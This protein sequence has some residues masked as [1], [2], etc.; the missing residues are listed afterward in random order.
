MIHMFM[1]GITQVH[2]LVCSC[3][4]QGLVTHLAFRPMLMWFGKQ[5]WNKIG[6]PLPLES[7]PGKRWD[8][9]SNSCSC[10]TALKRVASTIILF[11]LCLH[12]HR[13]R[14]KAQLLNLY[15]FQLMEMRTQLSEHLKMK[16]QT[17]LISFENVFKS[18]Y[19]QIN[20]C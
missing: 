11:L 12:L 15:D 9:T 6:S 8:K 14:L 7:V 13:V 16:I 10:F 20:I 5:E 3:R 4:E 19:R 18:E 17:F 1:K 2:S